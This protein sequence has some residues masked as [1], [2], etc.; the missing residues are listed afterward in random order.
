MTRDRNRIPR[1]FAN[2][3]VGGIGE[4]GYLSCPLD[5]PGQ[6]SLVR[7]AHSGNPAGDD[8]GTFRHERTQYLDIFEVDVIDLVRAE[9]AVSSLLPH[10]VLCRYRDGFLAFDTLGWSSAFLLLFPASF[11]FFSPFEIQIDA[12]CQEADHRITHLESSL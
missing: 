2:G 4:Q 9:F 7:T 6:L 12:Y 5:S 11:E 8:L 10:L 1:T 3:S